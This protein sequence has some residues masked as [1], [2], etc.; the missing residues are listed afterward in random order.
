MNAVGGLVGQMQQVSLNWWLTLS[1]LGLALVGMFG[2]LL[3]AEKVPS[4]SLVVVL[5]LV[6]GGLAAAE[7]RTTALN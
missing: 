7:V 3:V 6:I 4:E 2:G 5:A 1:F